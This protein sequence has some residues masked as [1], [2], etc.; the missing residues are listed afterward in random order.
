MVFP[1]LDM[2]TPPTTAAHLCVAVQQA[3]IA[4]SSQGDHQQ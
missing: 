3:W 1:I 4:L 2:D